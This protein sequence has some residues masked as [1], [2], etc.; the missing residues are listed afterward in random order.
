MLDPLKTSFYWS[1]TADKMENGPSF[2]DGPFLFGIIR[3][4]IRFKRMPNG[5][6]ELNLCRRRINVDISVD[7]HASIGD[8]CHNTPE[9]G[10][11]HLESWVELKSGIGGAIRQLK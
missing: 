10:F 6:A 11:D 4:N 1:A 8:L 9:W 2:M 7:I 5:W 3:I